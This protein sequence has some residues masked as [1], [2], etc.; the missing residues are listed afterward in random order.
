MAQRAADPGKERRRFWE[1]PLAIPHASLDNIPSLAQ[2]LARRSMRAACPA[3]LLWVDLGQNW[4]QR[5]RFRPVRRLLTGAR[6]RVVGHGITE[7]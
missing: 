6:D 7:R 4:G 1:M 2:P 5:L 3:T